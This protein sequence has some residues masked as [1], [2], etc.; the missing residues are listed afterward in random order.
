MRWFQPFAASA[1][2]GDVLA[3]RYVATT[4]GRH[5]L[6][7][8]GCMDLLWVDGVGTVLCGPDTRGWSFELP[9]GTAAAGVRFRPGAAAGVFRLEAAEIRDVRVD[10]AD[11]LGGRQGRLVGERL[12]AAEDPLERVGVLE[13]LV[14]RRTD[15]A[16]RDETIELAAL[17][18]SDQADGVERLAAQTGLS[19]RQ[20]RR[21][22]DRAVGYGPAF[23]GRI[24]RLQRFARSAWL[25]GPSAGSPSSP[26]AAGYVD[27]PHLAKDCRALAGVTP[28]QLIDRLPRSSVAATLTDVRT[29]RRAPAGRGSSAA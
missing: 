5:D 27:Q 29:V 19:G 26:I 13:E 1:D 20:L 8:D 14:R 2:L 10:L 17:V 6:I 23:F 15:D 21:R 24:A 11:L 18:E 25:G 3:C 4:D 16:D 28:R 7:P 22:F 9:P 12:S